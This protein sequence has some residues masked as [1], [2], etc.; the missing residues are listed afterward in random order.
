[1]GPDKA[2]AQGSR[3]F[4]APN[5][6]GKGKRDTVSIPVTRE[7]YVAVTSIAKLRDRPVAHILR[8]KLISEIVAEYQEKRKLFGEGVGK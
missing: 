8:E 1:M 3:G 4:V 7:E 2:R 5:G 6:K